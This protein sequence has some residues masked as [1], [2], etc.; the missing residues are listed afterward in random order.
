MNPDCRT[1]LETENL[2]SI[3]L[4]NLAIK[5]LAKSLLKDVFKP[6]NK[7]VNPDKKWK[8]LAWRLTPH[9]TCDS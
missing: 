6:A 4:E 2:E 5:Q 8:F 7:N 9:L 3:Y 1:I